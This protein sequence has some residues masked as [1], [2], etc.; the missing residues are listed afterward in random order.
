MKL[1]NKFEILIGHLDSSFKDIE[2]KLRRQGSI[3]DENIDPRV[4][5][6]FEKIKTLKNYHQ[7]KYDDA[8]YGKS[9]S[10][11]IKNCHLGNGK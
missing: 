6:K 3:D 8:M 1:G 5:E 4:K 9:V 7:Q 2:F 11:L 10:K